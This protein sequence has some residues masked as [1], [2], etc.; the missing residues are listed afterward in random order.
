M[1]GQVK[2]INH[3]RGMVAVLT[4]DGYSIFELLGGDS[5]EID[6]IVSWRNITPLGAALLTNHTQNEKYDVYFQNHHVS[7]EHV[8]SQLR[9][10]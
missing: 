1:Q 3:E 9:I 8:R 2:Q 6:D 10:R 4:S 7:S 5:I